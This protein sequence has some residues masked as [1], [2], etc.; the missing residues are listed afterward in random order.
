MGQKREGKKKEKQRTHDG[1]GL[2]ED[3]AKVR[4]RHDD[5]Q[6]LVP[7]AGAPDREGV[8][9]VVGLDGPVVELGGGGDVG[10]VEVEV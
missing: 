9:R 7:E 5:L 2:D 1:V 3:V 4:L 10:V 8:P 6:E